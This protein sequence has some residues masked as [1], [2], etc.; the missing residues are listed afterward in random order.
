M[1]IEMGIPSFFSHLV[2]NHGSI[3]KKLEKL[4][5]PI[6]NLYLDSNSIIYDSYYSIKKEYDGHDDTFEKKLIIKVLKKIEEYIIGLMPRNRVII[7]Y[8]GV[9]PIAKMEQ[10]RNRRYK[11]MLERKLRK[12]LYPEGNANEWKTTAITPGTNFMSKLDKMTNDYFNNNEKRYGLNEI[13]VSGTN[14]PGEGEHKLFEKI[15]EDKNHK[16]E[17]TIV[18]GLDADLIMLGLNHLPISKNIYLYRE[19]PEFIKS[20]NMD[21]NPNESY[22]LDIPELSRTIISSMN[23]GRKINSKQETN[24]LYDYIFL[25][26]FLGNDFLPHFPAINIRTKGIE[27]MIN[28]YKHLFG[29]TDKNLT[30]GSIIYWKNVNQLIEYLSENEWSNL[31]SEYKIRDKQETYSGKNEDEMDRYL[32]IPIR[33]REVEKY[34][35]PYIP[36]WQKRYYEV[37]FDSESTPE[38]VK[39]VS[40]NY[41]EGLEWVM[42]YYTTGCVDWRWHYKYYYPPLLSDLVKYTPKFNVEFV[43]KKPA[44]PVRDLVQLSYVL[45]KD[46]LEFLPNELYNYLIWQK[47]DNYKDNCEIKWSFCKYFWE[48]HVVLPPIDINELEDFVSKMKN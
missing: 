18:Y 31:T 15:R 44:E 29:D 4:N 38:Y 16:N 48:S 22:I 24:R 40:I 23:N 33:N 9:A 46:S 14:V 6:D 1:F 35:A 5:K 8:D 11:S 7:A 21:L 17:C 25:C 30:N 41:L 3:I 42:K 37:L 20:I 26:F 13:V 39:K 12:E 45:P 34:I 28:S 10:Q 27:I 43:K 2:K 32:R 19:T 47:K 36:Q